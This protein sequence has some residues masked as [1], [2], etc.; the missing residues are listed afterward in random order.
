[1]NCDPPCLLMYECFF[2]DGYTDI[3][4]LVNMWTFFLVVISRDWKCVSGKIT[5]QSELNSSGRRKTHVSIIWGQE[6]QSQ[7]VPLLFILILQT[8][9]SFPSCMACF[10]FN[11]RGNC[12][13]HFAVGNINADLQTCIN[14]KSWWKLYI[15]YVKSGC[16]FWPLLGKFNQNSV[17]VQ[18]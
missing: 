18:N 7:P 11:V 14:S 10:Y 2:C 15:W 1:M 13:G 17:K 3:Y 4:Y 12:G 9:N 8:P 6:K 5:I 16:K